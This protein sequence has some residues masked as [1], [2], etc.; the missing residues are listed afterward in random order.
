MAGGHDRGVPWES[1]SGKNKPMTV[2]GSRSEPITI[3]PPWTGAEI[4]DQLVGVHRAS[5]RFW[6]SF[7]IDEFVRPLGDAWSPADNVRHLMKSVRPVVSALRLPGPVLALLFGR[8]RVPSRGYQQ[9][10]ET[11]HARLAAG[12]RAGRFAPSPLAAPP[13]LEAWRVELMRRRTLTEMALA[14]AVRRLSER[15]LERRRLPH[16]L[17]G[18]LTVREMLL[19]TLYHGLHH[20]EN[21]RRRTSKPA[22]PGSFVADA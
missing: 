6:D 14:A 10:R 20:V 22:G 21:V 18:K 11:Y 1:P 7:S 16:P 4:A 13:D 17:L 15:T 12:G 5:G 3:V 19:F 9:L 2:D 8:G